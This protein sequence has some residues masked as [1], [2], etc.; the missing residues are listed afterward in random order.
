MESYNNTLIPP[1]GKKKKSPLGLVVMCVVV[2]LVLVGLSFLAKTFL[3][4]GEKQNPASFPALLSEDEIF[5][6]AVENI[7]VGNASEGRALLE[8]NIDTIRSPEIIGVYQLWIANSLRKENPKEFAR[9]MTNVATGPLFEKRTR[10]YAYAF[11]GDLYSVET[12]AEVL[13]EVVE[14]EAH[15]EFQ[16][17]NPDGSLNYRLTFI[18]ILQ[19][20]TKT[21]GD[22]PLVLARTASIAFGGIRSG[23]TAVTEAVTFGQIDDMLAQAI[24]LESD[25]LQTDT[26]SL[27]G[28]YLFLVAQV[29]GGQLY[30]PEG[31]SLETIRTLSVDDLY[32]RTINISSTGNMAIEAAARLNYALY[33]IELYERTPE[34]KTAEQRAGL[35]KRIEDLT[36]RFQNNSSM[37]NTPIMLLFF[38]AK[39]RNDEYIYSSMQKIVEYAPSFGKLM[40][41]KGAL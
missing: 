21:L 5:K 33:L 13:N 7:R 30:A 29:V 36:A 25:L 37:Q 34:E 3:W 12:R 39:K 19:N 17:K 38:S 8:Q 20:A 15:R 6:S 31:E 2:V 18:Q 40:E 11:L 28:T 16:A 23:D 4:K 1:L 22:N 26:A 27:Y 35:E 10:L 9:K 32:A 14:D 41:E 24:P